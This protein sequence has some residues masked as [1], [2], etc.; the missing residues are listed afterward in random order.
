MIR[1]RSNTPTTEFS[2][3]GDTSII[4]TPTNYYRHNKYE[5][6]PNKTKQPSSGVEMDACPF[7]S[8]FEMLQ[9]R[10]IQTGF[11]RRS[12]RLHAFMERY[13][14]LPATGHI[15]VCEAVSCLLKYSKIV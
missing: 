15:Y 2:E 5:D 7:N 4:I 1:I 8:S 10:S 6:S 12:N 14:S 11:L 9:I 13:P 3:K